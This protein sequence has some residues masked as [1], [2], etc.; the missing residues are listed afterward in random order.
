MLSA[1]FDWGL[2]EKINFRNNYYHS[3]YSESIGENDGELKE[4]RN[5]S[6]KIRKL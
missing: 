2:R 6:R 3:V 5:I 1:D 4:K